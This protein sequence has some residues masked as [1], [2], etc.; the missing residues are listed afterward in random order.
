MST[1][2]AYGDYSQVL[3]KKVVCLRCHAPIKKYNLQLLLTQDE[4]LC[5]VCKPVESPTKDTNHGLV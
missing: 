5:S 1:H 2:V 4:C 3:I